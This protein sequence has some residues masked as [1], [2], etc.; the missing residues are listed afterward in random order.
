MSVLARMA[1]AMTLSIGCAVVSTNSDAQAQRQGED[2]IT[3]I[4]SF[5]DKTMKL[6]E[7]T[8]IFR[9]LTGISR[10]DNGS[11]MFHNLA[12]RCWGFVDIVDKKP[13]G[14]GRCVE[15]DVEG[16]EI[17]HT[18]ENK[19]GVGAHYLIGGS[20]KYKGIS[21]EQAFAGVNIVKGPDGVAVMAISLKATW[22]LP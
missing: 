3:H 14:I 8:A 13:S 2:N 12:M 9:E 17:Y 21:G 7:R 16:D 10:N 11:G 15:V 6:G 4:F 22:K 18:F 20:G 1:L 19:A 5:T